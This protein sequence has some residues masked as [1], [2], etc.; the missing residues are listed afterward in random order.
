MTSQETSLAK[1]SER[2]LSLRTAEE[3]GLML[4]NNTFDCVN[5]WRFDNIAVQ[6]HF[7]SK[8]LDVYFQ[9]NEGAI[10]HV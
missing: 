2:H 1:A 9:Q 6:S 7:L 10:L 5:H 4:A 3:I 8:Q